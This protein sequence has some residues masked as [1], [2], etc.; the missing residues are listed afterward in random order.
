MDIGDIISFVNF[1]KYDI[2]STIV[3]ISGNAISVDNL[4]A[5]GGDTRSL[6]P[7]RSKPDHDDWCFFCPAKPLA[8]GVWLGD[9]AYSTGVNNKAI[10]AY[11]YADGKDNVAY[12]QYSHVEGRDN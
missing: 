12:G 8:G 5:G 9:A 3:G 7:I 4:P 11:S 10:N 1:N 6:L 2:G